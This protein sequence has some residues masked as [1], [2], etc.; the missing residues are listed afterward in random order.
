MHP[1]LQDCQSV[2]AA[3]QALPTAAPLLLGLASACYLRI[4]LSVDSGEL[5]A[6]TLDLLREEHSAPERAVPPEC[7]AIVRALE[8]A[9]DTD[10]DIDCAAQMREI[11][12]AGHLPYDTL[13]GAP[14]TLLRCSP[15]MAGRTGAL[16]TRFTVQYNL[17]SGS[18]VA[19]GTDEQR[20]ALFDAQGSGAL[21]CFAFTE[22]GAGVLSGAGVE[23]TATYDPAGDTFEIHSP[24]P[25]AVKN[26]ISQG[27]FAE[28]AVI[29][30]ELIMP[31][32]SSHGPH[33]F[34][35]KIAD[36]EPS[37]HVNHL[38]HVVVGDNPVKTAMRGLDNATI[39]F[40]HFKV[41]RT[42]L[43][44]RFGG[45][46]RKEG[47]G[48]QMVYVPNLPA[49]CH[50]MLDLLISRLLTGRIVLSEATLAHAM[51][52]MRSN[53][54]Y[55]TQRELW[56]GRHPKG[57]MMSEMPL[58]KMTFRDYSR[59][60]AVF[61]AFIE[62][63]REKVAEAIRTQNFTHELIESTCM[64]K[65]LGTGFGIDAVSAI[66]KTMGARALQEDSRL[67]PESFLPNATSA[68]EGDNT[69]MELKIVQDVVRGRTSKVPLGLML[70]VAA[71]HSAGRKAARTYVTQFSRAM[72]L[73]K[74]AMKDGNL[75]RSIAWS[76]AHMKVID[77]WLK[78]HA[79]SDAK[80]AAQRAWLSSYERV[81]VRFPVPL[82]M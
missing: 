21:G 22:K 24:T 54:S 27:C 81:A 35:A 36:R 62:D 12:A 30:A 67:G 32:G 37:G 23:T 40:N 74:N 19:M 72:L 13:V 42:A 68:A 45:L 71:G 31:D 80:S 6:S 2:L 64:C 9:R 26:W 57:R 17:Y 63:T 50:R 39:A 82:Q 53:W 38:A 29:H 5:D 46:E 8:N 56:H 75:L 28:F 47:G 11:V 48:S 44:S 34:W 77:V 3:P 43:L 60:V 49:G 73:Q 69:I 41:P 79:G 14:E 25:S 59:T 51:S 78:K 66:R 61:Q 55:A 18:I 33:L 4:C 58:I 52:R 20:A 10:S 70:R 65:F 15:G 1:L 76:R 16:W 7:L